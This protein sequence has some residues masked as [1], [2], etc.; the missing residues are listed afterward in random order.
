[1]AVLVV[2]AFEDLRLSGSITAKGTT[3]SKIRATKA[4]ERRINLLLARGL[5]FE[6][7]A[8]F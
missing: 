6:E 3:M 8:G 7:R 2:E 5:V 1:L 4:T